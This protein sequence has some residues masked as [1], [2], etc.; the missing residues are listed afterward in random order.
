MRLTT[1]SDAQEAVDLFRAFAANDTAV[2]PTLINWSN[3]L[4]F[5]KSRDADP[6]DRYVATSARRESD[7]VFVPLRDGGVD[8]IR[9]RQVLA[10]ALYRAVAL[11]E[12]IGVTLLAGTDLSF[13]RF[14]HPGFS[15]HEELAQRR[16]V[17]GLFKDHCVLP[18]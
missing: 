10:E 16:I 8:V 18:N 11:M 5:L 2:T 9:N 7:E 4:A 6:R 1:V 15:L 17:A 12:K 14:I 13:A 3:T